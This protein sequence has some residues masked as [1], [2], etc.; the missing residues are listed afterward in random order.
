MR[1]KASVR[2]WAAQADTNHLKCRVGRSGHIW[3]DYDDQKNSEIGNRT[4]RSGRIMPGEWQ[5]TVVCL[6]CDAT[7]VFSIDKRTG[8]PATH[9]R[10]KYDEGYLIK[11]GNGSLTRDEKGIVRL[12]LVGR[13][14][15][16]GA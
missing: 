5:V 16:S 13:A 1:S 3:S 10:V 4:D 2:K 6:R 9:A 14:M 12:E 7:V 8:V 15:K 11:D